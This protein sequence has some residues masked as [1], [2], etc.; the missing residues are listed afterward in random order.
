MEVNRDVW[1]HGQIT[2]KLWL[3]EKLENII[4][5]SK[6]TRPIIWIY[7]GWHGMTAFLLLSRNNFVIEKIYSFDV[8]PSCEKI[9]D[10]MNNNWEIDDWKFKAFTEDVN[11]DLLAKY[12][13]PP[14]IIINTS[15]EHME[16]N[17]W[18]EE[19]EPGTIVALQSNNFDHDGSILINSLKEMKEK[20][21]LT[22]IQYEGEKDFVY[23]DKS[24]TRYM[25]I[26]IK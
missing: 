7:G 3:C 13:N 17:V 20:Y 23:P 15:C 6:H 22:T 11:N 19:I 26:G 12:K 4:L 25:I 5:Q 21:P 1:S 16:E 18:F 24:F 9:A 14:D 10:M 8:D 2:S